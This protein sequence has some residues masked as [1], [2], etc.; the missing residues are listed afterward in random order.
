[1]FK[2]GAME[3]IAAS[4][5]EPDLKAANAL[6]FIAREFVALQEERHSADYDNAKV[7]S[8]TEAED[9]ITRAHDIYPMWNTVRDSPLAQSYS[10]DVMGG[11]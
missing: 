9:V 1:M 7:W 2:S 10:L 8:Y 4:P 11:R 5:S 6:E 3:R